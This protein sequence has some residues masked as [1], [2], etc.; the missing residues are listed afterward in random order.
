MA[1][2]GAD[3]ELMQT[4]IDLAVSQAS[5]AFGERLH[6]ALAQVYADTRKNTRHEITQ[7]AAACP[8][9]NEMGK[10]KVKIAGVVAGVMLVVGAGVGALFRYVLL[11]GG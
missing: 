6:T 3:R 7:H 5:E 2:S 1:M 8:V 9:S 10:Q 4:T 11:K